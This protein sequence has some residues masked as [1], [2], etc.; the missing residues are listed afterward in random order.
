MLASRRT[1]PCSGSSITTV[2]LTGE[3]VGCICHNVAP[4]SAEGGKSQ[5][6]A[7]FGN[8]NIKHENFNCYIL[9][10]NAE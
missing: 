7:H 9:D 4:L 6:H 1:K 2:R 5:S 10:Y 3:I 8:A